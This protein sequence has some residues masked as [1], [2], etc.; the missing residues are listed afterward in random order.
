MSGIS[1]NDEN[2]YYTNNLMTIYKTL[3]RNTPMKTVLGYF[4]LGQRTATKNV[5]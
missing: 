1:Q 5:R 4:W 3:G 2:E